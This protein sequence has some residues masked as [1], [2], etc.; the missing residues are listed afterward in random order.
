MYRAA[1]TNVTASAGHKKVIHTILKQ[2]I[3]RQVVGHT[4]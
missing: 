3:R 4:L 2:E 1:V